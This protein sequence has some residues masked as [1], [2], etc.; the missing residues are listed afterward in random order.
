MSVVSCCSYLLFTKR[1]YKLIA[2]KILWSLYSGTGLVSDILVVMIR[3]GSKMILKNFSVVQH[4]ILYQANNTFCLI[5]Q[6]P[7]PHI[8]FLANSDWMDLQN[9]SSLSR[10]TQLI[11]LST[12]FITFRPIRRFRFFVRFLYSIVWVNNEQ[13]VRTARCK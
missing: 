7:K 4:G 6:E 13:C 5:L 1:T 12:Y 3:N 8:K 11:G 9:H 10:F 2:D